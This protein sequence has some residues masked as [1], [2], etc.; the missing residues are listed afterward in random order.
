MA[1]K[2]RRVL[3]VHRDEVATAYLSQGWEIITVQI[4][5][6]E[7]QGR[8]GA[9]RAMGTVPMFSVYVMGEPEDKV[10]LTAVEAVRLVPPVGEPHIPNVASP[11]GREVVAGGVR[12][13]A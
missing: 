8:D 6:G 10:E 13:G 11:I 3:T 2:Y 7:P 4:V 12:K 9:G 5:K 1:T